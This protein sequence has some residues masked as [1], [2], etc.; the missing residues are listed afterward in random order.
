MEVSESERG[1]KRMAHAV[2]CAILDKLPLE[3]D[4]R[5]GRR[6]SGSR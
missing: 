4:W 5:G 1:G 3:A 2:N 6:K